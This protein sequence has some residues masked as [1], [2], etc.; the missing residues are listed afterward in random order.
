MARLR[1]KRGRCACGAVSFIVLAPDSY[2]ACHCTMCRRWSGGLWMGVVC[3]E[4][5]RIEGPVREW[6]SS[7][8][9]KRGFCGDC[10][11]SIWHKPRHSPHFTFG[12]GL[13]DDQK[14]WRLS[15][16]I[17][18]EGQPDHYALAD[19][20]QKAFTGWGTLWAVLLGRLP[21]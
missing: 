18:A 7:R 13:F 5:L 8:R 12:Q 9:A 15:R 10:G 4:I 19:R 14:G 20:G 2:G 11:T 21:K 1:E 6:T 16:E 3:S 17:C